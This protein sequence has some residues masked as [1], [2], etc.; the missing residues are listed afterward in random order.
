MFLDMTTSSV[1]SSNFLTS[2]AS[3]QVLD[4]QMDGRMSL[5]SGWVTLSSEKG[6][7]QAS[8]VVRAQDAIDRLTA[9]RNLPALAKSRPESQE[10]GNR[11]G[12][13]ARGLD[14]EEVCQFRVLAIEDRG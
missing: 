2:P 13:T 3:C 12:L 11:G 1:W 5:T 9:P 8:K 6:A 4:S 10:P 14:S 7:S